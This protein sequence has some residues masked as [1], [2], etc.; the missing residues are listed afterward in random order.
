MT[1]L[2]TI[3]TVFRLTVDSSR[4]QYSYKNLGINSLAG[5]NHARLIFGCNQLEKLEAAKAA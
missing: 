1:R 2:G 3:V 4:E 5:K